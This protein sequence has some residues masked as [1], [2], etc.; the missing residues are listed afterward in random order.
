[1]HSFSKMNSIASDLSYKDFIW[2]H[3]YDFPY[4]FGLCMYSI[5]C[6]NSIKL[7]NLLLHG[8]F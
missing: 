3:L 1:M 4:R 6:N 8:A 2:N 7:F 5:Y